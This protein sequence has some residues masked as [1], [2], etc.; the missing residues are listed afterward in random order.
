MPVLE[1]NAE[2]VLGK[3][4]E[5]RKVCDRQIN[6]SLRRW[7]GGVGGVV[8]VAGEGACVG[9]RVVRGCAWARGR[10]GSRCVRSRLGQ[11]ARHTHPPTL[12]PLPF[13]APSATFVSCW[14]LPSTPT[15]RSA[16]PSPRVSG[17]EGGGGWVWAGEA[18]GGG[19]CYAHPRTHASPA[20]PP[21]PCTRRLHL[22]RRLAFAANANCPCTRC[23]T[24]LGVHAARP[25]PA[26]PTLPLLILCLCPPPFPSP[27]TP[28]HSFSRRRP[29]RPAPPPILRARGRATALHL[30][31]NGRAVERASA[32]GSQGLPGGQARK[33]YA[34]E[35]PN[36]PRARPR[37]RP[38]RCRGR[39][40]PPSDGLGR[41]GAHHS[42]H[43]GVLWLQHPVDE[44]ILNS[45]HSGGG[46]GSVSGCRV[47]LWGGCAGWRGSS[48]VGRAPGL[49]TR[50]E[51]AAA[52]GPGVAG[53]GWRRALWQQQQ[54]QQQGETPGTEV[55]PTPALS[56]PRRG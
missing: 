49:C 29:R 39:R 16:A 34:G 27:H 44:V 4:F 23:C 1:G 41:L 21:T 17:L 46:G 48:R 25:R 14:W 33:V 28:H 54:Q 52:Q 6:D 56:S 3:H 32:E 19:F 30:P 36:S 12:P 55:W 26:P 5:I 20:R 9:V 10:V 24:F 7:V 42:A 31:C 2:E 43:S 50:A 11:L 51:A 37:S 13:P 45:L 22:G 47:G 15:M 8:V 18:R 40:H 53:P 38:R 35:S